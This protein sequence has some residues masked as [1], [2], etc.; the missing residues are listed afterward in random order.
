MLTLTKKTDYALIALVHLARDGE[1]SV[2][3]RK[4]AERYGVPLPLLMNVLKALTRG[5]VVRSARGPKGG[6]SLALRADEITLEQLIGV[7][8]GPVRFV[9]CAGPH[10]DGSPMT[11]ELLDTCSVRW[12]ANRIHQRLRRFLGGITLAELAAEP[13]PVPLVIAGDPPERSARSALPQL[14]PA[15]KS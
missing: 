14:E 10:G 1:R 5:G 6:Y 7:I 3:A 8:E 11:C 12:P 4:I 15:G 2:S 9:Q 13:A